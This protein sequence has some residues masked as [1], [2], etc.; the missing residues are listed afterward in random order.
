MAPWPTV[1]SHLYLKL[2]LMMIITEK[3]TGIEGD[4]KKLMMMTLSRFPN[5]ARMA[6]A[7]SRTRVYPR[8]LHN[9]LSTMERTNRCKI[10]YAQ[11]FL[12]G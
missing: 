7:F 12:S 8:R 3:D 5:D 10:L 9:I 1:K 6:I 11:A 4:L 2:L